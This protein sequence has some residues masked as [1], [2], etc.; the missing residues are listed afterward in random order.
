MVALF[1]IAGT[2]VKSQPGSNFLYTVCVQCYIFHPLSQL[3]PVYV[4]YCADLNSQYSALC[5][6]NDV[7]DKDLMKLFP[8]YE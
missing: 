2:G 3:S 1:S 8:Q 4:A 6:L 7:Y 5:M